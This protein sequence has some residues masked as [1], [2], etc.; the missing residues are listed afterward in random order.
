MSGATHNDSIEGLG[1][2]RV[3]TPLGWAASN[4]DVPMVRYLLERKAD[5]NKATPLGTPLT[6][7]AQKNSAR[8]AEVLLAH[9]ART[10]IKSGD[11][12]TPL[13]W[14]AMSESPHP[15]LV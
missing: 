4:N 13:H 15:K 11:G 3:R 5:P 9:G 1:A 6:M 12:S 14:A 7:A 2:F 10:D 8:A